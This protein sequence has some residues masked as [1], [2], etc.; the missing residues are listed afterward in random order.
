MAPRAYRWLE[1]QEA[2]GGIEKR[3]AQSHLPM[4]P[5]VDAQLR[6]TNLQMEQAVTRV[7]ANFQRMVGKCP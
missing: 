5:V 7:G 6:D 2:P 3:G 1:P 4:L